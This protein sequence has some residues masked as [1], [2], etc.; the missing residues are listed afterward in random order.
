MLLLFHPHGSAFYSPPVKYFR[1]PGNQDGFRLI[2]EMQG[3]IK[4]SAF[5]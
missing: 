4:N 5:E 3:Y 2:D 1:L